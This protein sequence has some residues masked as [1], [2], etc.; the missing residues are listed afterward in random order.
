MVMKDPLSSFINLV[1][2]DQEIFSLRQKIVQAEESLVELQ[3]K[4][5]G[6]K[7]G[8]GELQQL[9]NESR[10]KVNEKELEMDELNAREQEQKKH[11]D[12]ATNKK[13]YESATSEIEILK[14]KQREIEAELIGVWHQFDG[15][16]KEYDTKQATA[17]EEQETIDRLIAE[18]NKGID[19]LQSEVDQHIVVR[20]GKQKGIPE[21]WLDKYGVMINRVTD[22]V[23]SVLNSSCAA[24]F[25]FI[26][27]QDRMRL[28]QGALLQCNGC[29]R[30]LYLG[31]TDPE[32]EKQ[33]D[34][35]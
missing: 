25:H 9:F 11:L 24:C 34:S 5:T 19:Q 22:P 15:V 21:E 17:T 7:E 4:E 10:K 20:E 3:K 29:Y 18:K 2:F 28:K 12:E 26:T 31:P 32:T 6:I 27:E 14:Q 1:Q 33:S 16:K 8:V 35:S 30:F 23:V 13:E